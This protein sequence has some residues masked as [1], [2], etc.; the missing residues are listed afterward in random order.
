MHARRALRLEVVLQRL[1]R[2]LEDLHLHRTAVA[3]ARPPRREHRVARLGE[4]LDAPPVLRREDD[5]GGVLERE[6]GEVFE[7]AAPCA[8]TPRAVGARDI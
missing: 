4:A 2:G 1:A 6:R 8:T 5:V 3:V 7:N